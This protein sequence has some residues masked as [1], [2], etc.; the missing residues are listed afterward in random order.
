M[1]LWTPWHE[2]ILEVLLG[3]QVC[4]PPEELELDL[5]EGPFQP[6][7]KRG[8]LLMITLGS[9]VEALHGNVKGGHHAKNN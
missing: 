9:L 2:A 6:H 3:L 4:Y 5:I 7:G 8:D 1:C